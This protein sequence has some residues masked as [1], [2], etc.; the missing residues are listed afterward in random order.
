MSFKHKITFK[1]TETSENQKE[2]DLVL[3]LPVVDYDI[4]KKL[5]LRDLIRDTDN[6]RLIDV[7]QSVYGIP[8]YLFIFAVYTVDNSLIGAVKGKP[9]PFKVRLNGDAAS[10]DITSG[11]LF[12]GGEVSSL[13]IETP[14]TDYIEYQVFLGA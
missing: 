10:K 2:N 8:K 3:P 5:I 1:L 13:Y 7:P 4:Q 11:V 6:L 9:A 12:W 14:V